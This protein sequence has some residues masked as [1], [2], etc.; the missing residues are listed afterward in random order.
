MVE[1]EAAAR[2]AEEGH[3]A[4]ETQPLISH[5][6][7]R[8]NQ[9]GWRRQQSH[10]DIPNEESFE[11]LN[12]KVPVNVRN[13]FIKKVYG[14]LTVELLWTAAICCI[15]MFWDP[16]RLGTVAFTKAHPWM[17]MGGMF[18][19][20]LSSLCALM[21]KKNS[22][23]ENFQ[24][25]FLFI[26]VMG[27]M[28]GVVCAVKYEAGHGIKIAQALAITSVVF[29]TLSAYAHYSK[30]DFSFM[31]GFLIC[32]LWGNILFGFVAIMTGS[33]LLVFFYH[34]MGVMLFCGFILYD[35]S[36]LI[37]KYGCDDY[38]IASVELYLD[39]VNLF[40]HIL[41]LLGGD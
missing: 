35:T 12:G 10:W 5:E 19:S 17:F 40:L 3:A 24:F 21:L 4:S 26:T 20:M 13:D 14:I 41:A 11:E 25:L 8:T 15:F 31:E 18:V 30:T 1:G 16:L 2:R 27:C 9:K 37:Y 28:V 38:I 39:F 34:A 23:P 36:A 6:N 22:Y 32:A 7:S 33:S 29:G